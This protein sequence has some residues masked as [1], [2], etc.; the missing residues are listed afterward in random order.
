M[1]VGPPWSPFSYVNWELIWCDNRLS[2]T[3]HRGLIPLAKL[4][5]TGFKG[6]FR[7]ITAVKCY[8]L[9]ISISY[10]VEL[11]EHAQLSLLLR[12]QSCHSYLNKPS[13]VQS[14]TSRNG[15]NQGWKI[16]IEMDKRTQLQTSRYNWSVQS[17]MSWKI[18]IK[19]IN[20]WCYP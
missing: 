14:S 9:H 13:H 7:Y 12:S 6:S 20:Q 2:V 5:L 10:D 17:S 18:T 19:T 15:S 3:L 4:V 8:T 16:E 11:S 1:P